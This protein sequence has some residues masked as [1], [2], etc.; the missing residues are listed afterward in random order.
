MSYVCDI[1]EH[2]FGLKTDLERH[3]MK[4]NKCETKSQKYSRENIIIDEFVKNIDNNNVND[5]TCKY[6]NKV[7]YKKSN[8]IRHLINSCAHK[9]VYDMAKQEVRPQI[10]YDIVIGQI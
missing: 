10:L 2:I 3:K 8:V 9:N 4:K 6:C 7:F 5:T 1:C